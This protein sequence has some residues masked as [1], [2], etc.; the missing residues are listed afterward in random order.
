MKGKM[1]ILISSILTFSSCVNNQN[2]KVSS[3]DSLSINTDSNKKKQINEDLNNANKLYVFGDSVSIRKKP[4]DTSKIVSTVSWFKSFSCY[5]Y[6]FD[7]NHNYSNSLISAEWVCIKTNNNDSSWVKLQN[8]TYR[9]DID[10]SEE[11][12]VIHQYSGGEYGSI[13]YCASAIVKEKM[14]VYLDWLIDKKGEWINDK[15]FLFSSNKNFKKNY[16]NSPFS[17]VYLFD[18]KTEKL[19]EVSLGRNPILSSDKKNILYL[20]NYN[21]EKEWTNCELCKYDLESGTNKTLYSEKNDSAQLCVFYPDGISCTEIEITK[22]NKIDFYSFH[23]YISK[24]ERPDGMP[25]K[26]VNVKVNE[27]G[28]LIYRK[29]E[30]IK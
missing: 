2:N 16:N 9:I 26:K 29:T 14:L 23:L 25:T 15:Y 7:Y 5:K 24:P 1:I 17:Y 28:E 21:S 11:Y 20:K 3:T 12:R 30:S 27:F 18:K 6:Y 10:S 8:V 19:I 22:E 13:D 4:Y